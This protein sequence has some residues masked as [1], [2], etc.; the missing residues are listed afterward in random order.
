MIRSPLLFLCLTAA[1]IAAEPASKP[2]FE[3]SS[4]SAKCKQ[5]LAEVKADLKG[6]KELYL[7]VS[8]EGA[9]SCDWA[10]WLEPKLIMA[11][12]SI[13]ELTTLAW[14]SAKAG[15]GK[16][17][18]GKTAMGGA[19]TV[20]KKEYT[21]GIGTHAASIIA[22]D[23]PAGVQGFTATGAI[24]DGGMVRAGKASDASVKF[25]IYTAKPT[26]I[27]QGNLNAGP[28]FVP[29][30]LFSVPEGLEVTLWAT[31]PMLYNPTNI[32]FDAEGRMYVAEGVDYR[33]K[34]GRRPEG[35]RIVVL[36]DTT[37]SGRADK[38]SVFVQEQNLA[39]PLG[40]AVLGD[41]IVVS[42]PPDL[43][44]YTDVDH[45]G[46]FDP[47]VDKRDV[48]LTGFGGRQHDH[49]LHS[50][51]AGPDGQ[52]YFNQGNTGAEFTD[53]SGKTFHM[54][55]PYMKQ[56]IAGMKSDDGN[57][58]IGGFTARMNPD[59]T[60]VK[61]IGHNYRNSFEQTINSFGDIYQS[62]NDDPPA[63]RVTQIMEGGNAGFASTDGK[64]SWGADKRPG[65]DTPT[66]EWR[67][68]DPGTMPA[69]DVYGGGSP[70]GVAFYENGALGDQWRGLLLA[71]EAGKNVV[72]GYL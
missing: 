20:D 57:V 5:R 62:D 41:K 47:A 61:I 27:Q 6:A 48:L 45:N 70:T 13:K 9:N 1:A 42:M 30:D 26:E 22:Y 69:G 66:A 2:V 56:E 72:F 67:Q 34:A 37:G 15:S 29:V 38:S 53:R 12:G 14:K 64:R 21:R 40:V 28:P 49:S 24:D 33:G 51:T 8:D 59:G 11:D 7:V 52:W 35:D 18:I 68:E 10:D 4:L 65:Q 54:G 50:L 39:A 43:L 58:W 36:E 16:V 60:N 31:S 44:V 3:S 71:C 55:S 25:Q 32:D 63:C 17:N 19:L 23:L 46:K